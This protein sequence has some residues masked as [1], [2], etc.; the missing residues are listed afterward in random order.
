[1]VLDITAADED[2]RMPFVLHVNQVALTAA[3]TLDPLEVRG[4]VRPDHA[5]D[6]R[7]GVSVSGRSPS[8]DRRFAEAEREGWLG[9]IE[10]LRVSL[11]GA[12]SKISQIETAPGDG[13]DVVELAAERFALGA[14]A[15]VSDV[16]RECPGAHGGSVVEAEVRP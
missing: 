4:R 1:M 7:A 10:G 15:V 13:A 6:E 8:P 11:T 12:E 5:A 14:V 16:H 2:V 3:E 9:E